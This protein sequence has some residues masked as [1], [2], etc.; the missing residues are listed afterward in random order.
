MVWR[1]CSTMA[2]FCWAIT[3]GTVMP[4]K[5]PITKITTSSSTMVKPLGRLSLRVLRSV[6]V[7]FP[8]TACIY[9]VH[10]LRIVAGNGNNP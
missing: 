5:M 2:F 9:Y 1:V 6:I 10:L 4:T 8:G 7:A 3:T